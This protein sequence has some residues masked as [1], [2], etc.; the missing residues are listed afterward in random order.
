[1]CVAG[2]LLQTAAEQRAG[3][4]DT[5]AGAGPLAPTLGAQ[6][7]RSGPTCEPPTRVCMDLLAYSTFS[8]FSVQRSQLARSS[9][10]PRDD[11]VQ[12]KE[13][14]IEQLEGAQEKVC[15]SR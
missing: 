13:Q 12:E 4:E 3:I 11:L 2:N 7:T 5:E 14:F 6:S 15:E 9:S 1:M 10:V 8:P